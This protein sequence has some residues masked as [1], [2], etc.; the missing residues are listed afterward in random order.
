MFKIDVGKF[1]EANKPNLRDRPSGI[2][3]ISGLPLPHAGTVLYG[4]G[5]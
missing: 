4:A 3:T 2:G 5:V 1:S